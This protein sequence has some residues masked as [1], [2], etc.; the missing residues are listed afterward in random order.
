MK[1]PR[2]EAF[3][4]PDKCTCPK[5]T[6][7][8]KLMPLLFFETIVLVALVPIFFLD[9]GRVSAQTSFPDPANEHACPSHTG[10]GG[11]AEA[12]PAFVGPGTD[13]FSPNQSLCLP[14][15]AP[16]GTSA[17]PLA[18]IVRGLEPSA[19]VD[20]QGTIYVQSIRGVPGGL[21]LWRWSQAIDGPPNANGTLP[22]K[23]EGQPDNCGIFGLS[24]G[25]CVNNVGSPT[26]LGIAPGGGDG[27][28]AV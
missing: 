21:D 6:S 3:P 17:N 5:E 12:I 27:D 22:F 11:G 13:G 28:I 23:Y 7:M 20:S 15:L 1:C 25:G 14:Q 24:G 19:R 8:R 16:I 9:P 26:N 10:A 18:F 4:Q 2:E